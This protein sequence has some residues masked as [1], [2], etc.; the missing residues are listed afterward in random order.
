MASNQSNGGDE[1][2]KEWPPE[3][4]SATIEYVGVEGIVMGKVTNENLYVAYVIIGISLSKP[5]PIINE[6]FVVG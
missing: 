1:P 3:P 4:T 5:D 6:D 2:G